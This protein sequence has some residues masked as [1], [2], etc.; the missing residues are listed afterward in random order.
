MRLNCFKFRTESRSPIVSGGKT[1]GWDIKNSGFRNNES[2]PLTTGSQ[3]AKVTGRRRKEKAGH[4]LTSTT[5]AK[6]NT[7]PQARR[8][9]RIPCEIPARLTGVNSQ[10]SFSD[11]CVVVLIN[12]YGCA[13]RS[14]HRV[15]VGATVRLDDLPAKASAIARVVSCISFGDA[16]KFC[17]LGLA[18]DEPGNV[19]GVEKPPEDWNR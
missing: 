2:S 4:H 5:V 16:E 13:V 8:A 7:G 15:D 17:L 10:Y 6:F 14:P 1:S 18:L 19:W 9:T 12:P 11:S 3:T